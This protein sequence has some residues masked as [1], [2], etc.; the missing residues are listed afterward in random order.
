MANVAG[1]QPSS[2]Q[3][4]QAAETL[5]RLTWAK[6]HGALNP[7]QEKALVELVTEYAET[8]DPTVIESE[9]L[10]QRMAAVLDE[11]DT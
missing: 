4:T 10:F 7:S 8:P 3:L 9:S 5:Y 6:A 1:K 11:N 2:A